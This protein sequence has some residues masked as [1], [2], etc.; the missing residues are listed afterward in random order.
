MTFSKHARLAALFVSTLVIGACTADTSFRSRVES[1]LADN[2]SDLSP[3]VAVT[4]DFSVTD[5]EWVDDDTV[6]VTYADEGDVELIGIGDAVDD[7]G[8]VLIRN[9]RIDTSGSS[10]SIPSSFS[11]FSSMA[12]INVS[13]ASAISAVTTTS[14]SM[15]PVSS[16][17]NVSSAASTVTASS[18]YSYSL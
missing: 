11:S 8:T 1:Y 17:M 18:S 12:S 3:R 5:I 7:E 6:R 16:A 2:I 14:S 15:M 9:F 13:S 10:S 4:G